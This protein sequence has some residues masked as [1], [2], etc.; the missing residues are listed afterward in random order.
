MNQLGFAVIPQDDAG[1]SLNW[2]VILI[3]ALI[4]FAVFKVTEQGK[5]R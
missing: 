1:S 2:K 5:T 3:A 4:A